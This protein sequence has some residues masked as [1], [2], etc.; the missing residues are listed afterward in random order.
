MQYDLSSQS[1]PSQ[2]N[3][4]PPPSRKSYEAPRILSHEILEAVA[5]SGPQPQ[6]PACGG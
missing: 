5:G 6:D 2:N 1:Q 3:P 4:Q